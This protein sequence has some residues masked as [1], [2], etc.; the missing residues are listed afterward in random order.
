[1]SRVGY[2]NHR[3]R[4][5]IFTPPSVSGSSRAALELS[6]L[7]I[8]KLKILFAAADACAMFGPKL[9]KEPTPSEPLTTAI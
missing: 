9:N 3:S 2:L 1:M 8:L 7:Q 5:S 4:S 6:V